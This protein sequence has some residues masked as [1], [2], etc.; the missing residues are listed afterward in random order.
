MGE[1]YE[2][3]TSAQREADTIEAIKELSTRL[4]EVKTVLNEIKTEL[5]AIKENTAP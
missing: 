2:L 4:N 1:N 5:Q 3:K